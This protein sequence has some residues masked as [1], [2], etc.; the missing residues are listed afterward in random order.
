MRSF[1]N[2]RPHIS[3]YFPNKTS[4]VIQ[5]LFGVEEDSTWKTSSR[6]IGKHNILNVS[7]ILLKNLSFSMAKLVSNLVPIVI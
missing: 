6:D 1:S 4:N 3:S 2:W 5:N 7:S